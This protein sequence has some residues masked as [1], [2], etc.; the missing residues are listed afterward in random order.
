[1][2]MM[3]MMIEGRRDGMKEVRKKERK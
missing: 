1:M 2:M 3:M